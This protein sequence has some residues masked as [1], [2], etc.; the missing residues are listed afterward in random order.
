M[1]RSDKEITEMKEIEK[2]LKEAF[3]CHL[4]LV[5][6]DQ[7]YVV[8]MNYAYKDGCIYLHCA[9]E[10]RKLDLIEKNNK[11]CFEMEITPGNIVK[12]GD[13]PCDW[14]T[15]YRSVI[16]TGLA[17]LLTSREDKMKALKA[18]VATLDDRDLSFHEGDFSVTTVIRI[19]I[20][21]MTGKAAIS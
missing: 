19:D 14:G 11:V 21:E 20:K 5:D 13:Q 18:I 4:G 17:T 15:V 7:P 9:A 8:P 16:G 12:N 2:I 3:V 10:G 6:G 1:R